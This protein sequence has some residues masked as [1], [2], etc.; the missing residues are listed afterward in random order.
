MIGIGPPQQKPRTI[1]LAA[2]L[3]A[4][5][6]H[7]GG[8]ALALSSMQ[9]DSDVELG[10]PALEI[11]VE[12]VSPR[13]EPND[14]PAGPDT[15][16]SAASPSI[17]EQKMVVEQRDL[18]RALPTETDDLDRAVTPNETKKPREEDPKVTAVQATP[19]AESAAAEETATPTVA[20]AVE[21]PRSVAPALG[22]G[23]SAVRERQNWQTELAA[24]FNKYK[25][26]PADRVM[27][28]AEVVVSFVLDRLG[29]VLSTRIVKGSGDA[30][31]DDAALSM[32]QRAN[33]VPPPPPVVAD[34]GLTFTLPVIFHAKEIV[35]GQ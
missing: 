25:R 26:Y 22:T 4:I 13:L 10:A 17:V 28:R 35:K 8:V 15:Q 16:A 18:P 3:G 19:S 7:A 14:L 29:R 5:A 20:S 21:A 33:P 2:A 9:P 6:L 31:F 30:S 24:H 34:E 11:G 12:L 32:L 23:E 27:Q 1:W